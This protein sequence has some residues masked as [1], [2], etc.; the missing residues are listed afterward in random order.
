M[1][2]TGL[3]T[4]LLRFGFKPDEGPSPRPP[5]R[6]GTP[7]EFTAVDLDFFARE[8]ELYRTPDDFDDL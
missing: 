4:L 2:L 1:F 3:V 5:H 8:A 6:R 7:A